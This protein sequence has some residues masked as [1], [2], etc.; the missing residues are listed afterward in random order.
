M[1]TGGCRFRQLFRLP[2]RGANGRDRHQQCRRR[3][4]QGKAEDKSLPTPE[5]GQESNAARRDRQGPGD[6]RH[7]RLHLRKPED[8]RY[9]RPGDADRHRET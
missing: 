6:Y 1:T 2:L 9:R 3:Q 4:A 7:A 8:H 5:P